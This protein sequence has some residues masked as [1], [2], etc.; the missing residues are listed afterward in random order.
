MNTQQ[1]DLAAL[2]DHL[3]ARLTR[4]G[5]ERQADLDRHGTLYAEFRDWCAVSALPPTSAHL[6]AWRASRPIDKAVST[7]SLARLRGALE[8]SADA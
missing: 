7:R 1:A 2:E 6:E 8:G 5:R 3:L 4:S